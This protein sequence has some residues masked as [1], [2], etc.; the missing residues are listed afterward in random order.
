MFLDTCVRPAVLTL[1]SHAL[2]VFPVES[3]GEDTDAK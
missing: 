1:A 3:L 2:V